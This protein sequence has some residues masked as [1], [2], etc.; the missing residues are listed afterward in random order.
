MARVRGKVVS[1][2]MTFSPAKAWT[3]EFLRTIDCRNR[4]A[5][6]WDRKD[7]W[8]TENLAEDA[9][10]LI[11]A[12]KEH[13]V[14]TIWPGFA[15][16]WLRWDLSQTG[17]GAA[18][19]TDAHQ[20]MP[21]AQ[22]SGHWKFPMTEKHINDL[23]AH[24]LLR[25][26]YALEPFLAVRVIKLEGD[27]VTANA[28][29]TEFKGVI[30]LD[31]ITKLV[32]A[33]AQA[34]SVSLLPVEYVNTKLN[35][36]ADARRRG[37]DMSDWEISDAVWSLIEQRWEP[38]TWDRFVAITNTRRS[39]FRARYYQLGCHWPDSLTQEWESENNYACPPESLIF[40]ALLKVE[41]SDSE[42]T[43]IVPS[44]PSRWWPLLARLKKDYIDLP[45]PM[46]AFRQGPSG[47]V[48][49]WKPVG[50]RQRR[51]YLAVRVRARKAQPR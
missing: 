5:W 48:E 13:N 25:V 23:E 40:Q 14:R 44:C 27:S 43:I 19:G 34:V 51:L 15:T 31:R 22:A 3:S 47:H 49:P 26:L 4:P 11:Q 9:T 38:H 21:V 8:I 18:I 29:I 50:T 37:L 28:A 16:I 12:L 41:H 36:W 1:A 45:P 33:W 30:A 24:A 32:W 7:I 46:A 20:R 39:N 17:W 35:N 2:Q 10:F 6:A 42:A